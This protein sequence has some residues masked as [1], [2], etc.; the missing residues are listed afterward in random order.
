MKKYLFIF[1]VFSFLLSCMQNQEPNLPEEPEENPYSM[2]CSCNDD[3]VVQ[4]P[5]DRDEPAWDY[6]V[7]TNTEEWKQL[8]EQLKT[9]EVRRAVF[10]IP[11]DILSSLSTEGLTDICLDYPLLVTDLGTSHERALD[12]LFETFNG[13]GELIKR[14][15]A[16]N[17]LLHWYENAV[18]NFSIFLDGSVSAEKGRFTFKI[19]VAELLLARCQV[20]EDAGKDDY[21]EIVQHL[22]CGYEKMLAYPE[23]FGGYSWDF[24]YFS[25]LKV[26]LKI[27]ERIMD[28]IPHGFENHLF[29]QRP[30]YSDEDEAEQIIS[31]AQA[32]IA[33]GEHSC[34]FMN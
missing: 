13:I 5:T 26:M 23:A 4:P 2:P 20:A 6:P 11:E 29:T 28:D 30:Y 15:D 27:D 22:V 34:R 10:Q 9:V 3:W 14:K 21:A 1:P 19:M 18:Q 8:R 12:R 25:R 33:I 16:V 24:N 17:E 32:I 7:K 31:H